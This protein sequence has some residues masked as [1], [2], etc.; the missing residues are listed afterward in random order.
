[1]FGSCNGLFRLLLQ[2]WDTIMR[3]VDRFEWLVEQAIEKKS[4][5]AKRRY[6]KR[7]L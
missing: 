4:N 5:T 7:E 1:M 3:Q 2:D 6:A